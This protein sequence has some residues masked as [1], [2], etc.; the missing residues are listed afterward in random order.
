MAQIGTDV[1]LD[2]CPPIFVDIKPFNTMWAQM[3]R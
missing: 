3:H 2:L 1:S